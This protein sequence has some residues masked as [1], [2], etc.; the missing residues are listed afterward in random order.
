MKSLYRL[1]IIAGLIGFTISLPVLAFPTAPPG[2]YKSLEDTFIQENRVLGSELNPQKENPV[3][4]KQDNNKT[5]WEWR[6]QP[7]DNESSYRPLQDT[8]GQRL[9]ANAYPDNSADISR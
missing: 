8:T 5:Q 3:N 7:V 1:Q 6:T 4:P 9:P 2:P